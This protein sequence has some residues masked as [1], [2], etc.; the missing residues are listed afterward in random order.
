MAATHAH[1]PQSQLDQ[2]GAPEGIDA[3]AIL[4]AGYASVPFSVDPTVCF[5]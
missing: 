2:L 4:C 3:G 5:T 1:L